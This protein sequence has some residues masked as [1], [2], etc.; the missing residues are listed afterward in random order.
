MAHLSKDKTILLPCDDPEWSNFTKFFVKNFNRY[1]I[2][3]LIST[4][5]A[6]NSKPKNIPYQ[7]TLF[8]EESE[9]FD[10]EKFTKLANILKDA[11]ALDRTRFKKTSS[12]V[13]QEK[14]LRFPYSKTLIKLAEEINYYYVV[15]EIEEVYPKFEE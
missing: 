2:K 1:G 7:L 3:K 14:Y 13:L 11:D 4:S 15:K 9:N 10:K 6:P 12:A 8:E 5:Y